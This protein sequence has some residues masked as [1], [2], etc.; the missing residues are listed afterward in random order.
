MSISRANG[1]KYQQVHTA[2]WVVNKHCWN[3]KCW[4]RTN[5]LRP[6]QCTW[7]QKIKGWNLQIFLLWYSPSSHAFRGEGIGALKKALQ[8]FMRKFLWLGQICLVFYSP[9][10]CSTASP[11]QQYGYLI[12]CSGQESSA[13]C[14]Q[15]FFS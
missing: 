7:L 11:H 15:N 2:D 4:F 1:L 10:S 8:I 3:A 14:F 9:V 5:K 12:K 13:Q 6:S